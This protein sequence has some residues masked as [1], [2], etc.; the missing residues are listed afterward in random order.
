[1]ADHPTRTQPTRATDPARDAYAGS[2]D[3]PVPAPN[4][5]GGGHAKGYTADPRPE[6]EVPEKDPLPL[7]P[8]DAVRGHVRKPDQSRAVLPSERSGY[9]P[10]DRVT[11]SDR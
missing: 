2:L 3:A 6:P 1:V 7:A 11:G 5:P 10:N 4:D 9:S 8:D